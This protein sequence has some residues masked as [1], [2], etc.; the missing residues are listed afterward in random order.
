MPTPSHSHGKS[1]RILGAKLTK[2]AEESDALEA[3]GCAAAPI[4]NPEA[5][6]ICVAEQAKA[7]GFNPVIQRTGL[8]YF[9]NHI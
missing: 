8:Q 7:S 9:S 4:E 3:T 6:S 1:N 2:H 5:S